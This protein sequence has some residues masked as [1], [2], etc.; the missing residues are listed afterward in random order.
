MNRAVISIGVKNTGDLPELQAAVQSAQAVE[1][2]ALEHQKIPAAQVKLITDLNGRVTRDQIFDAVKAFTKLG[3]LDQ[4]IVYFSGHGIN[5]GYHEQWLLSG[6]PDDPGAA[7]NVKGS[8]FNARFSGINH[9]VFI[10]DACRTAAATIQAQGV[11]GGEIFPNSNVSGPERAVD[12]FFAALVGNPALEV[13]TLAEAQANYRAAYS[14]KLMEALDGSV[15]ALIEHT[16]VGLVVRPRPLKK[17]LATVVPAFLDSLHLPGGITQLPDARIESDIDAVIATIAD[18]PA[19][20]APPKPAGPIPAPSGASRG[21][22]RG[23]RTSR[24]AAPAP[25]AAT[26]GARGLDALVREQLDAVLRPNS[27]KAAPPRT[28]ATR[29]ATRG[30]AHAPAPALA[31]QQATVTAAVERGATDFGPREF[32]TQ[33]GIK[34]RG[35]KLRDVY[36]RHANAQIGG[37]GDIVRVVVDGDRPAANVLLRLDDG[38]VVV[39]PAFRRYIAAASFDV[40][41]SF[42]D[43][44]Y[45]P[46]LN[47]PDGPAWKVNEPQVRELRAVIAGASALGVFR[48]DDAAD[49]SDLLERMRRVKLFDPAL[50]VYAA[51]AMH[52]RRMRESIRDMQEYLE[53]E[54]RARIFD[55]AMLGRSLTRHVK[56]PQRTPVF[57]MF[58]MLAQGWPLLAPLDVDMP[59]RVL[60]LRQH[61]RPSLWTHFAPEAWEGLRQILATGEAG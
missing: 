48:L 2:W 16:P 27:S 32:E 24:G 12:Q 57:P 37:Q 25:G 9:V 39:I 56:A 18:P 49:A 13:K 33:C 45:A 36:A 7:V 47:T 59:A 11:T 6:A 43:L 15:P 3:F 53:H 28:G 38:S 10:S 8:E 40:D 29:G 31:R 50:A 52:D 60:V 58:P 20:P 34:V 21:A 26:P 1:R 17:H 46:S 54:L 22:T 23:G 4:L 14:T 61:L 42:D 55:V 51:H 5:A 19:P 30:A 41:G 44:A 35:T